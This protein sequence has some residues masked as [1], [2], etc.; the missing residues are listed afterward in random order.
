MHGSQKH[1]QNVV[2]NSEAYIHQESLRDF[3]LAIDTF[4]TS[5]FFSSDFGF[6]LSL[7][8]PGGPPGNFG[9][10]IPTLF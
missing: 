5:H 1:A 2:P 9:M 7:K 6:F 4:R 10:N 3:N 8:L